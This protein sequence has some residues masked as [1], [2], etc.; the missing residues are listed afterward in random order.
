MKKCP[1]CGE[2]IT[3]WQACKYT[4][5]TPIVCK[6]CNARL[7]VSQKELAKIL[8]PTVIFNLMVLLIVS[9]VPRTTS[10]AIKSSIGIVIFI[11]AIFIIVNLIKSFKSI[12]LEIINKKNKATPEIFVSN[13]NSEDKRKM[14]KRSKP[15]RIYMVIIIFCTL[16]GASINVWTAH[17]IGKFYNLT[18]R[19]V[20]GMHKIAHI[21][22][23]Y[24]GYEVLII[25]KL[26]AALMY[27]IIGIFTIISFCILKY[28]IRPKIKNSQKT[29]NG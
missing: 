20:V 17:R 12:K 21:D 15:V 23:I 8:I 26:G 18:F 10:K 22:R 24:Q 27:L 1:K 6:N 5:W 28:F 2:K 7:T 4:R 3:F 14:N 29:V 16:F 25:Q 13:L 19:E 9:F 11:V